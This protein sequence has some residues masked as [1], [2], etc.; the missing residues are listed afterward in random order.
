MENKIENLCSKSLKRK[1]PKVIANSNK[2]RRMETMGEGSQQRDY[3]EL[4][5]RNRFPFDTTVDDLEKLMEG[6]CPANTAKNNEWAYKNFTSWR[7]ARNQ[8]F[9]DMQ[10]PDDVFSSKEVAC[11]WLC[12]Y[13]SETRKADGSEYTPRSLYLLLAGLQRYVRSMHPTM[14]INFFT[15]D[16]FKPLKNLCDSI[17]KRLHSKGIGTSLKAAAV[18]SADDEKKLWDTKVLDLETPVGLLRAVFF[19]NGKN[20]CL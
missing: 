6:E 15:D 10:C 16:E 18:L 14:K 9:P 13:V 11:E 3:D 19:Y 7:A 4:E 12:K 5:N 17:F 20:F 1:K 8:R 2:Q